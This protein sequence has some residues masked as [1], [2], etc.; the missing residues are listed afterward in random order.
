MDLDKLDKTIKEL[1]QSSKQI[2]G[3]S[4]IFSELAKLQN[5]VSQNNDF[6]KSAASKLEKISAAL[7]DELKAFK[8]TFKE[9]ENTLMSRLDRHKSDIQVDIRNEGT[10]IQ[11][12]FENSLTSNFNRLENKVNEQ[13]KTFEGQIKGNKTLIIICLISGIINIGMLIYLMTK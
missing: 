1:D 7:E 6:F 8:A 11:R 3:F 9:L 13:F 12:G 5:A 10:Q 2:K 4:E